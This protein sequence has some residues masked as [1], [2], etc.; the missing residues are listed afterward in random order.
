MREDVK[1]K[2]AVGCRNTYHAKPRRIWLAVAFAL[3]LTILGSVALFALVQNAGPY[4]DLIRDNFYTGAPS[5]S[6]T[7][8]DRAFSPTGLAILRLTLWPAVLFILLEAGAAYSVSKLVRLEGRF[9]ATRR[10]LMA[11]GLSLLTTLM[12]LV[13]TW[14]VLERFA[15]RVPD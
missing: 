7:A 5:S 10:V 4:V 15:T 14:W 1:Q 13:P 6:D 3:A 11:S 9:A 8:F 2:P 12:L